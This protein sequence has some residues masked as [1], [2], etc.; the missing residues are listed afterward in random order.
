MGAVDRYHDGREEIGA[1]V[2]RR[3]PSAV[4]REHHERSTLFSFEDLY[5]VSP[6]RRRRD[7]VL[8]RPVVEAVQHGSGEIV[9]RSRGR[10]DRALGMNR[11]SPLGTACTRH[12]RDREEP[13]RN[14]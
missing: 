13:D 14:A 4:R 5:R 2:G 8:D 12:Q 1:D 6:L 9:R 7:V 3:D 11:R 10:L